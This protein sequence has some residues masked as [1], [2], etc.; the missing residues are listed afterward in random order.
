MVKTMKQAGKVFSTVIIAVTVLSSIFLLIPVI[1]GSVPPG[2][3]YQGRYKENGLFITGSRVFKFKITNADGSTVYWGSKVAELTVDRG[4]FNYV[5]N[6]ATVPWSDTTPYIEVLVGPQ[7]STSEAEL[8]LLLPREKIQST[9][10]SVYVSSATHSQKSGT[11]TIDYFVKFTNTNIIGNSILIPTG[12]SLGIGTASPNSKLEVVSEIA[13]TYPTPGTTYGS[14]TISPSGTDGDS[15]SL[16]FRANNGGSL[17]AG[18]QAGVYVQSSGSLPGTKMYF[19]TTDNYTTGAQARMM[20][21]HTGNVGIN[22]INPSDKLTVNGN[23]NLWN[24]YK[25]YI[26]TD[27][28]ITLAGYLESGLNSDLSLV[29]KITSKWYR[30]GANNNSIGFWTDN[31]AENN[32]DPQMVLNSAGKVGM[33]VSSPGFKVET[34]SDTWV[35]NTWTINRD[36]FVID[37]GSTGYITNNAYKNNAGT[38]I[39]ADATNKAVSINL[40]DT[41][42]IELYGTVTSAATDWRQM[43]VVDGP[44]EQTYFPNGNIS[45]AGNVE[46]Y[47]V[48]LAGDLKLSGA[49]SNTIFFGSGTR[50]APGASSSGAKIQLYG[51]LGSVVSN[52]YWV[53]ANTDVLWFTTDIQ[54]KY[55]KNSA[56][57]D[58]GFGMMMKTGGYLGVGS[59]TPDFPLEVYGEFGSSTF[60]ATGGWRL[61]KGS[62]ATT[63]WLYLMRAG[64]YAYQDFNIGGLYSGSAQRYANIDDIA[65]MMDV[66]PSENIQPGEIVIPSPADGLRV[67]RC[68]TAYCT[69]VV[70]VVSSEKTAS[71]II[72][73]QGDPAVDMK[74]STRKPIAIS[75]PI[76]VKVNLENGPI[77]RGDSLTSS[78]TPGYAMKCSMKTVGQKLKSRGAVI[79]KAMQSFNGNV[80]KNTGVIAALITLN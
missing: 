18:A 19:A 60:G 26:T 8:T 73:G 61:G 30:I 70:G 14:V 1:R 49:T 31:N 39:N 80:F 77:R 32:D 53:G 37:G 79:G 6:C 50:A 23:I 36:A 41:G 62:T 33:G 44:N 68:K 21:D 67:V 69:E 54:Y 3:N 2:I 51:T 9:A 7:G 27:A 15:A 78:S 11:G 24:S 10:Y 34:S 48:N 45:I 29:Q 16:T 55:Y 25:L 22:T 65:E 47:K 20:I 12:A 38:W 42:M 76:Y 66:D 5:I 40:S 59:S 57:T 56:M 52:H 75:G 58:G 74:S 13:H 28:G 35:G 4:L 46:T 43:M 72:G 64:T 17:A 71:L 63:T